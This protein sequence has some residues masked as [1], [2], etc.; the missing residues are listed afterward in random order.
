ML[1]V[2]RIRGDF[3]LINT[4]GLVYLDSAATS[5]KPKQ[6]ID[7]ITDFY[8]N[9]NANVARGLYKLAEEATMDYEA[10]RQSVQKFINAENNNEIIFTQ[11]TTYAINIIM[12]GWGK[13]IK[14]GD[15]IV[16]TVMEHHSNFVPWQFLANSKKA[17]FVVVD[18]TEDGQI[19]L[20]DFEKKVKGAKLVA[21]ST[22]SNVL[23]TVNDTKRLCKI[24]HDAGA[25]CVVDGAQSV[26]SM[27]TDIKKLD[28]DFL[29]F[30]GHKMLAPFG[31]GV[32]YGREEILEKCDPFLYGSQMIRKVSTTKSEWNALPFKFESGTPSVSAAL[33]LGIAIEYL[34]KIGIENVYKHEI[35]LVNYMEKRLSE[36]GGLQ[37]LGPNS[38]NRSGLVSFTLDGVH[39]HDVSAML[40]ED[41]IC[42]RSGHHCA[43]PIHERFKIGASSRASIYLYNK[44]EEVDL[45]IDSLN[46][47]KKIFG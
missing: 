3:P 30:S 45:M 29:A 10:V 16:T 26:P 43:M 9:K 31:I 28:C 39:P 5:Q 34:N 35:S 37:I 24:A 6:V 23:G 41:N 20:V 18:V 19:D 42:I 47:V 32:L 7:S 40:A 1:N 8:T 14:K 44:K 4:P 38:K 36:I 17:K 15:K 27:P 2:E 11:N 21:I 22:V 12:R 25:I 33:G 46:R 13:Y